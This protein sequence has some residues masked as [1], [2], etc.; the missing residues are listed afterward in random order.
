MISSQ[1][2]RLVRC[3][4]CLDAGPGPVPPLEVAGSDWRCV[5]CGSRY[6]V[7]PGA[8]Y[9]DLRPRHAGQSDPEP[10]AAEDPPPESQD[11]RA[12]APLRLEAAVYNRLLSRM[13]G[14][15][16]RDRVLDLGCGNGQ[17][18]LWNRTQVQSS[19]G[20]DPAARFADDALGFL[21]LVRGDTGM[22]PFLSNSFSKIWSLHVLE[23][24]DHPAGARFLA[25]AYRVLAPGGRMVIASRTRAPRWFERWTARETRPTA[26]EA[27]LG[28]STWDEIAA[29]VTASGFEIRRVVYWNG[30]FQRGV[31]LVRRASG[32]AGRAPATFDPAPEYQ[33]VLGTRRPGLPSRLWEGGLVYGSLRGLTSLLWLDILLF[34]RIRNAPYFLLLRKP[35]QAG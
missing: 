19:V 32:A 20:I 24:L 9:V 22:L 6:P 34:G 14:L 27:P 29:A 35:K 18:L 3:P 33:D 7:L 5:R 23:H 31:A 12:V 25:E 13:L 26:D 4:A 17:F 1:L 2:W 15:Q 21:D 28:E 10:A 8:G 11:Y 16:A 30:V